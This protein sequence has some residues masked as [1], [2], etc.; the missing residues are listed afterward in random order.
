MAEGT[1]EQ[2]KTENSWDLGF[3]AQVMK[4]IDDRSFFQDWLGHVLK[5]SAAIFGGLLVLVGLL[6]ALGILTHE[7]LTG[8]EGMGG[9][10]AW[11]MMV[12]AFVY[13]I[14]LVWNRA[15]QIKA[16]QSETITQMGIHCLKIYV[17]LFSLVVLTAIAGL[18]CA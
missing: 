3:V 8:A 18:P 16:G 12:G 2:S 5:A 4:R 1:E 13:G 14:K 7:R 10:T 15:D 9:F 17:E 6:S 11:L